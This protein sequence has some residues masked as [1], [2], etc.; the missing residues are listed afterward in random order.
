MKRLP[1]LALSF[2]T[3][4]LALPAGAVTTEVLAPC[5]NPDGLTVVSP[6]AGFSGVVPTPVG[7]AFFGPSPVEDA[8][9][10]LIDLAGRPVGSRTT[11]TTVLS[12]DVSGEFGDYDTL[13]NGAEE[14]VDDSTDFPDEHAVANIRHCQVL[15]LETRVFFGLPIDEL[16]LAVTAS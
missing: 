12:W 14:D 4:A 1:A 5:P 10:Y 7:F 8:G 6:A 2:A 15:D 16:T 3:M 11:V 9:A 13:I